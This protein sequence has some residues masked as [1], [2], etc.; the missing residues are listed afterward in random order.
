MTQSQARGRLYLVTSIEAF[1]AEHN[2]RLIPK[3]ESR[4]MRVIGFFSQHFYEDFWTT[5]RV[6]FGKTTITY[7]DSVEDPLDDSDILDHELAHVP[8]W[9]PWYGP[10][11]VTSLAFLFPLPFLFSGRWFIERPAFLKDI[12]AK[13][14]TVDEVVDILWTSYLWAWPRPLMRKWLIA[15][16]RK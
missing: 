4:P 5:Y 1:E 16:L 12:R 15:E 13:R 10:V 3:S 9:E 7:P 14:L 11:W 6:W 8:Q 2:C